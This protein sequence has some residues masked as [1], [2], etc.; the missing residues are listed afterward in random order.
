MMCEVQSPNGRYRLGEVVHGA[1]EDEKGEIVEPATMP[2]LAM[3][4]SVRLDVE[5][6]VK[7]LGL[8]VI[9][10]S[11][12]WETDDGRRTMQRFF[13]YN[14]GMVGFLEL[15]DGRTDRA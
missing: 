5:G 2:E 11:V 4:E 1:E 9:I 14:V 10:V 13:K 12:A 8:G 6:E 3:G 15:Q 7:D